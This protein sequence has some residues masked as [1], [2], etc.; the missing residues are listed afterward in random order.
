MIMP[1][2]Q[3]PHWNAPFSAKAFCSG[4]RVPFLANPSMVVTSCPRTSFTGNWQ[5]RTASLPTITVHAP[6]RL[7][8]QPNLVPVSPRSVR[9]T[10]KSMLSPSTSNF[11]G[12]PLSRKSMI[13]FIVVSSWI[14][15]NCFI[16]PSLNNNKDDL[17]FLHLL[18]YSSRTDS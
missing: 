8:P 17:S 14:D 11:V 10:H 9:N 2:V 3:K 15:D 13:S 7:A 18:F 1:G 16:L 6:Q 4:W 5:D 12:L